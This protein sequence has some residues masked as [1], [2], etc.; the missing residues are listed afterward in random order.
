MA[1]YR[2]PSS[3]LIFELLNVFVCNW[4]DLRLDP[5]FPVPAN[6]YTDLK[7]PQGT[8]TAEDRLFT[9][10][11]KIGVARRNAIFTVSPKSR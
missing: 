11:N 4:E 6:I 3:R 8:V 10:G 1:T 9:F 7:D 5:F 2:P